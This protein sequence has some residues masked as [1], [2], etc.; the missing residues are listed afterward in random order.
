MAPHDDFKNGL[1]LALREKYPAMYKDFRRWCK[2]SGPKPGMVWVWQGVD[3]GGK[4]TRIAA[5][6]TQDPP[7]HAG[8]HPGR[9][10]TEHVNRALHE[11][12]SVVEQGGFASV[13]LPRLATGVG[14]LDWAHV[15]P[16]LRSQLADLKVP[17][18]VYTTYQKG[19]AGE[20]AAA[21]A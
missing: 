13:A 10:R 17:V 15:E 8:G 18:Y 12:R 9:A 3:E 5:L 6:L 19:V 20:E 11:L 14:G 7:S 4:T 2:T 21:P 1:A 16:L